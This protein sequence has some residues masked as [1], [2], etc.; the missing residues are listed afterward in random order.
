MTYFAEARARAARRKSAWNLLLIPAVVLPW[1]SLW[2]GL[3]R[4]LV[5][6]HE[7]LHGGDPRITTAS[8]V[9]PIL[10]AV[11]PA[12]ASLPIAMLLGNICV[13]LIPPARRAL[14]KEAEGYPRCSFTESQRGLLRLGAVIIPIAT[15]IAGL[16]AVVRWK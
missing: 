6:L 8:G 3:A 2:Y 11:V 13:W 4:L 16:G 15:A 5:V 7:T 1:L 12:F 10:V 9:G 14:D